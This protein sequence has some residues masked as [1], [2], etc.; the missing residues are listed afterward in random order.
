MSP[1][2]C[3]WYLGQTQPAQIVQLTLQKKKKKGEA[4]KNVNKKDVFM[5]L[6]NTSWKARGSALANM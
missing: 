5:H 6:V 1:K 4:I 2:P 3:S